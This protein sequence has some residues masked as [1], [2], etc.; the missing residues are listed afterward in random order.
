MKLILSTACAVAVVVAATT[1]IAEPGFYARKPLNSP[2]KVIAS[3][4]ADPKH[5]NYQVIYIAGDGTV[6]EQAK[7]PVIDRYKFRVTAPQGQVYFMD[8][9]HVGQKPLGQGSHDN[10]GT[11]QWLLWH[12]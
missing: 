12:W 8:R 4:I 11:A 10:N 7:Y 2:G 6:F 3:P 9:V 1:A 5:P